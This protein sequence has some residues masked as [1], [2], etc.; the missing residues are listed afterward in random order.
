MLARELSRQG[1][2]VAHAFH[3]DQERLVVGEP[4]RVQLGDLVAKVILQLVDVVAVEPG[5]VPDER[6]PLRDL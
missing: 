5:R 2:E 6:P 4:G 3:G 1:V